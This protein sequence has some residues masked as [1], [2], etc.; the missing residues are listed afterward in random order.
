MSDSFCSQR[1]L[2][3]LPEPADE[4]FF[5]S[6]QTDPISLQNSNPS[7]AKPA[8][9]KD[10]QAFQKA[11]EEA[12]LGVVICLPADPND[13]SS[14]PVPVGTIHLS[15]LSQKLAHH[16]FTE[17]GVQIVKP[18]QGRGYGSEAINWALEWAFDTAGVHR[19][20]IKALGYNQGAIKLYGKLGFKQE[21]VSRDMWW[22]AGSWWDDIQFGMLDWEWRELRKNKLKVT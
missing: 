19:V 18:Y 2:Y 20:G 8:S 4:A 7:L 3:R 13:A 12:L 17:M 11:V 15:P 22:H 16:R 5:F 21:G 1:L 6:T 9:K 10:A 14:L